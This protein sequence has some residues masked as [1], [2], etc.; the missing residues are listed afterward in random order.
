[1]I[2]VLSGL[3]FRRRG[4]EANQA[5]P[6]SLPLV[7]RIVSTCPLRDPACDR[8][9]LRVSFGKRTF[10]DRKNMLHARSSPESGTH[11]GNSAA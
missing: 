1:M 8:R 7:G 11:A 9:D 4:E 5:S 6:A 3:G 2:Q 10:P